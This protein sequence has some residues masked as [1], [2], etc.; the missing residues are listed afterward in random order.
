[1]AGIGYRETWNGD[2]IVADLRRDMK[3]RLALAGQVVADQIR[4]NISVATSSAGPSA[5]GGFPHADTGKL[6][7]SIEYKMEGD[8]TVL[9]GSPL[10]YARHLELGT[11]TMAPRP[12]IRRTIRQMVRVIDK[13][14]WG[15]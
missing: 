6:R 4:K 15:Q 5:P 13:I 9:V 2:K 1:M 14:L 8:D 10:V 11:S 12:F 7:Q 3:R